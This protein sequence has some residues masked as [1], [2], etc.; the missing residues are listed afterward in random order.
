MNIQRSKVI[1]GSMRPR[2]E[3]LSHAKPKRLQN[4]FPSLTY[5]KK[6]Y[7]GG[8]RSASS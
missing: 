2:G 1:P 8:R 7:R 5:P 6:V 3:R 4:N